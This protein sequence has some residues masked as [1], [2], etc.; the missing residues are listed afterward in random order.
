MSLGQLEGP[1]RTRTVHEYV[2]KSLRDAI[3]DGRLTGGT[4]LVQTDLATQFEVSITPVREALRD[5][6]TEGL[7]AF[8]PHRGALVRILDLDE[9]REVYELRMALEPLMVRRVIERITSEQLAHADE[10]RHQMEQTESVSAWAELNRQF[11]GFV[12]QQYHLIDDLTV[13]ENIETPLSYRDVPK[14][15]R[16]FHNTLAE[17]DKDSRLSNILNGLRDTSS[18]YVAMS[19]AASPERIIEA[20]VEHAQLIELFKRND[21]NGAVRLSV[22][23]LQSTIDTIE[24]AHD[25][26]A[27]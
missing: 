13:Y 20:D 2:L 8:D 22:Q 7:V 1:A 14:G 5:L 15:E 24:E 25:R 4:H 21:A 12:F 23:H 3:I 18:S 6:A 19:L 17:S 9:V 16:Q 10:L 26:G 27:L 11:I